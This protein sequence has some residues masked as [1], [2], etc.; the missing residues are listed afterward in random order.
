MIKLLNKKIIIICLV[1]LLV[2][3]L[4]PNT[5]AYAIDA[6]N[7]CE[8]LE[9]YSISEALN[10]EE[11]ISYLNE[12]G[13]INEII[14]AQE[15]IR[16]SEY[17]NAAAYAKSSNTRNTTHITGD[18]VK[19][20]V[21]KYELELPDETESGF[22]D[23]GQIFVQR[24][25]TRAI[26]DTWYIFYMVSDYSFSIN[27]HGLEDTNVLESITGMIS[28]N[29]LNNTTWTKRTDTRFEVY[30]VTDGTAF[31]WNIEKWGVK[32]R[33]EY[34]IVVTDN[35]IQNRYDNLGDDHEYKRYNFDAKPYNMF[36]ANG[37]HRHHFVSA[38][39]LNRKGY[40]SNAAY[41]IR[42]M[43]PDHYLT[44]SYGNSAYVAQETSLIL[45]DRFVDLI[46]K[47]INDLQAKQDSEG[48]NMNL[49]Q[50]YF[51]EVVACI[52]YYQTLFEI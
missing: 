48:T 23:N 6:F 49:Q 11:I 12:S 13:E 8:S 43:V 17:N 7:C 31:T 47:E 22:I 35:G 4:M 25:E 3:V 30:N 18:Y 39:A 34:I 20:I 51:Y 29:Y 37:G 44:G 50:K 26:L 41:C 42:M 24:D 40:N 45:S 1:W 5:K 10:N 21:E 32:E 52:D 38:T 28:C 15:Q 33:F 27:V 19:E 36:S 46:N 14:E 2:T 9:T 16:L